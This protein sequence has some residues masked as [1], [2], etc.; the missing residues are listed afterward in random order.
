MST[1]P[2]PTRQ[3]AGAAP[4]LGPFPSVPRVIYAQNPL[5][6][7]ICQL[8]F[9][10]I[11]RIEAELPAAFQD[12]IR[13]VFPIYQEQSIPASPLAGLS[14]P[15]E[16]MQLVEANFLGSQKPPYAF[17]SE[18]GQWSVTM[19][20]D[21][22]ALATST[23][24][25]WELFR[26]YLD[27][28]LQ[29]LEE[30]YKPAFY[31]RAG[32]RYRNVIRRSRLGLASNGWQDLLRNQLAGELA[33]PEIA[34]VIEKANRQ[35]LIK[36]PAFDSRVQVRHGLSLDNDETC[37][38]IDNDFFAEHKTESSDVIGTLEYF[39]VQAHRLFRWF[40]TDRL[41]EAMRPQPIS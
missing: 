14:L 11:L 6:E 1:S 35:T 5:R 2:Q 39:N 16:L 21:F 18:D 17:R 19:A 8:R 37:Y 20:K 10:S 36:L 27:R 12:R 29:A 24:Q 3:P 7:V 38:V 23:Y 9:P 26:E 33:A 13:D 4:A 25:K 41:H 31:S 28:P 34:D 40:I 22:I 15:A 32:L 30:I